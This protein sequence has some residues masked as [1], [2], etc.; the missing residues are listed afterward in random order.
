ME[1]PKHTSSCVHA[2]LNSLTKYA[3]LPELQSI[4]VCKS[5]SHLLLSQYLLLFIFT[6]RTYSFYSHTPVKNNITFTRD[7]VLSVKVVGWHITSVYLKASCCLIT[8]RH[9]MTNNFRAYCN[10]A[11]RMVQSPSLFCCFC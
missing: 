10:R 6:P 7:N 11:A 4:Y 3:A 2:K 1:E 8:S 9:L 5:L